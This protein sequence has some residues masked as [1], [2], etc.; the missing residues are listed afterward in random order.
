MNAPTVSFPQICKKKKE[1][2]YSVY[3]YLNVHVYV[4]VYVCMHV[5]SDSFLNGLIIDID[6]HRNYRLIK[7]I[8]TC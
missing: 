4:H 3:M 6:T 5:Y 2:C 8:T 7:K 1:P